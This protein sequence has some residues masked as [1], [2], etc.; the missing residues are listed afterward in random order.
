MP[1]IPVLHEDPM[2]KHI[3]GMLDLIG[4]ADD[5]I[6]GFDVWNNNVLVVKFI[7]KTVGK[8]GTL[9]APEST[10]REDMWQGKAGYVVKIGP[11]AFKDD[12]DL[13]IKFYGQ[14]ARPGDW[15]MYRNSD[16]IDFDYLSP[17]G[18]RIPCRILEDSHIQMTVPR[19]DLL[20]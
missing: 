13:G 5:P 19:P 2:V 14:K 9:V 20:Y 18:A 4:G 12:P 1:E 3:R 10:Q 17:R 15:V 11:S 7:R 16:G 8:S 6:P